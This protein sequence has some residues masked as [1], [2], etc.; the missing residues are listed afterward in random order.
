MEL[1]EVGQ[2]EECG[3]A[4]KFSIIWREEE[5]KKRPIFRVGTV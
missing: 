2:A 4:I 1:F 3:R 5:R